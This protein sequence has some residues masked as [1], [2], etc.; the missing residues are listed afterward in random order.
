MARQSFTHR[1]LHPTIAQ[2]ISG[3]ICE[4]GAYRR[5]AD[6]TIPC[7]PPDSALAAQPCAS[8]QHAHAQAGGPVSVHTARTPPDLRMNSHE[9]ALSYL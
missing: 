3:T 1:A 9:Y 5:A 6:T 8:V 2:E 4:H 7:R